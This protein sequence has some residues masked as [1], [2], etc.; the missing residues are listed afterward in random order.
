V[1]K[2]TQ[3]VLGT[4]SAFSLPPTKHSGHRIMVG[5]KQA[6]LMVGVYVGGNGL[7]VF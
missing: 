4:M 2:T 3:G 7:E 1:N 6:A 5:R